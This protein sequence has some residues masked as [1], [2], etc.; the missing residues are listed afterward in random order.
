[1]Y[2]IVS[3]PNITGTNGSS[4]LY[5]ETNCYAW[6]LVDNLISNAAMH[7]IRGLDAINYEPGAYYVLDKAYLDFRRLSIIDYS[8][9][10]FI[11]RAKRPLLLKR[12]YSQSSNRK[13]GVLSDQTV[14]LT[15][16]ETSKKYPA[17]LRRIKFKDE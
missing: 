13:N 16:V 9:A 6:Y 15:G 5:V 7:D 11:T 8:K 12:I 10:Y 4:T 2:L 3:L 17:K 14:R 1:V